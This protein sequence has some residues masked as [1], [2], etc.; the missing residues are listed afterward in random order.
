MLEHL[1][2]LVVGYTFIQ[3]LAKPQFPD[4]D[5][6]VLPLCLARLDGPLFFPPELPAF[7]DDL[8]G[9][10]FKGHKQARIAI[11]LVGACDSELQSECALSGSRWAHEQEVPGPGGFSWNRLMRAMVLARDS[12]G[13]PKAEYWSSMMIFDASP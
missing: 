10:L 4:S 3:A 11:D 5:I 9:S 7:L 12:E 8:G 1:G 2:D 6:L 13:M